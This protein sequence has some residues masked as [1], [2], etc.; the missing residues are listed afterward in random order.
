MVSLFFV[1]HLLEVMVENSVQTRIPRIHFDLIQTSFTIYKKGEIAR[2]QKIICGR[3]RET[4]RSI[5]NRARGIEKE[6]HERGKEQ[7]GKRAGQK[8]GKK[9][10][11]RARE[12]K[13]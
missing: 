1:S 6:K 9:A 5:R 10:R 8:E 7:E 3:R 12:E 2:E 13:S 4:G 11:E